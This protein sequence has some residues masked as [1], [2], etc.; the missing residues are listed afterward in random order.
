MGSDVGGARV[1]RL[2]PDLWRTY[3]DV[4]LAALIDTPRAFWATY[5]E[6]A[7]RPDEEWQTFVAHALVWLALDGDRPAGLVG[8]Y[9]SDDQPEEEVHLVQ[10]WVASSARG[11]GVADA[12]VGAALDHARRHG[13]TRVR[14]EALRDNR[15]AWDFY[16]R[17]GFLP[18]GET[19]AMPWDP[20]AV[21]EAMVLEVPSTRGSG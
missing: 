20:S 4:R 3:R 5:A 7:Q 16:L 14:L 10:M 18:T 19:T 21:E 1:V 12:L 8:I 9:H 17:L 2:T 13:W 6:E 11:S 15:R